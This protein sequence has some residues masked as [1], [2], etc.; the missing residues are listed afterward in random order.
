MAPH[1]SN[2]STH[3][4]A[5]PMR[6]HIAEPR[7]LHLLLSDFSSAI[8][9]ADHSQALLTYALDRHESPPVPKPNPNLVQQGFGDDAPS[10]SYEP[11]SLESQRTQRKLSGQDEP[12]PLPIE[13]AR[14]IPCHGRS[15]LSEAFPY[16]TPAYTISGPPALF[17]RGSSS[18]LL[19]RTSR[20]MTKPQLRPPASPEDL[21]I[22]PAYSN[23]DI[24]DS[25]GYGLVALPRSGVHSFGAP[26]NTVDHG[27][28]SAWRSEQSLDGFVGFGDQE[29]VALPAS[30]RPFSEHW[31]GDG[32]R[33]MDCLESS[34]LGSM[35]IMGSGSHRVE[36]LP[37]VMV[38]RDMNL[39]GIPDLDLGF[40]LYAELAV[41]QRRRETGF[42]SPVDPQCPIFDFDTLRAA[43]QR[44]RGVDFWSVIT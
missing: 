16:P 7:P 40:D 26:C 4:P 24:E 36:A 44:A 8:G 28:G 33:R 21:A 3:S 42:C 17:R 39:P 1:R 13:D 38:Q 23:F 20:S 19:A 25:K 6:I 10:F 31:R 14:Q 22:P 35:E 9:T 27:G 43:T 41:A 15:G 30:A 5:L 18:S 2:Y 12:K 29:M 37:K 32:V 11:S 34:G